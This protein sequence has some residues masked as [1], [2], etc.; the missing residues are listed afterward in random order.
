VILCDLAV[1]AAGLA[2]W[3]LGTIQRARSPRPES[4]WSES[5]YRGGSVGGGHIVGDVLGSH[6]GH[7][8]LH[9]RH[10]AGKARAQLLPMTITAPSRDLDLPL[11]F[12]DARPRNWSVLAG[13]GLTFTVGLFLFLFGARRIRRL[14]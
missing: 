8:R 2:W 13:F 3:L 6:D 5:S 1:L 4:R 7:L 11:Q 9:H 10:P 14:G 12:P